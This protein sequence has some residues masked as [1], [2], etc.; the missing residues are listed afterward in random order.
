MRNDQWLK[1]KNWI[2]RT[3]WHAFSVKMNEILHK[4]VESLS[5]AGRYEHWK[6]RK[7][8]KI[9][10]FN[11]FQI[12]INKKWEPFQLITFFSL[13]SSLN[14][15]LIA[16]VFPFTAT[17]WWSKLIKIQHFFQHVR[18]EIICTKFISEHRRIHL[19]KK[20]N[21][22]FTVQ[23]IQYYFFFKKM[24]LKCDYFMIDLDVWRSIMLVSCRLIASV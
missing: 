15:G 20:K 22:D 18:F 17:S 9:G 4:L 13:L 6:I 2:V 24:L 14:K 3:I 23:V 1:F 7:A 10:F 5:Y 19:F 8:N 12:S 11:D 16:T 21:I